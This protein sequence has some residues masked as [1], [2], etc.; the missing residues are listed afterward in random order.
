MATPAATTN[1]ETVTNAAAASLAIKTLAKSAVIT[2]R[3]V[4]GTAPELSKKESG[5]RDIKT[6]KRN[7]SAHG[8]STRLAEMLSLA[9]VGFSL[10][11][12][13]AMITYEINY[14]SGISG[15]NICGRVGNVLAG[16]CFILLGKAA[17]IPVAFGAVWSVILFFRGAVDSSL[18]K[19]FGVFVFT[20]AI[21]ILLE[22]RIPFDSGNGDP[23]GGLL[24]SLTT[25]YV[26]H[27]FGAFGTYLIVGIV[28]SIAFTMATD[29]AFVPLIREAANHLKRA[30][31]EVRDRAVEVSEAESWN[32]RMWALV[33]GFL[34]KADTKKDGKKD[35]KSLFSELESAD[36]KKPLSNAATLV[37]NAPIVKE[38]PAPAIPVEVVKEPVA[39]KIVEKESAKKK[40]NKTGDATKD[41]TQAALPFP[42]IPYTLPEPKLLDD[43][44]KGAVGN[45]NEDVRLMAQRIEEVLHSFG[46]EVGVVGASRGPAVTL[47]ELEMGEGVTVNLLTAR[48]HDLAIRLKSGG[49]RFVYPIPGKSTVGVEVPNQ[50]REFVRLRELIDEVPPSKVKA[51]IPLYLGRDVM[52]QAVVADLAEMPHVLIA[53]QT[54]SGKSACLN[55]ILCSLLLARD[56]DEVKLILVDPKQVEFSKYDAIPHLMCPIVTVARKVPIVLDWVIAEMENRYEL[57]AKGG[58]RKISDF[59]AI[60]KKELKERM[61][62]YYVPDETQLRLPYIV[63][64]VDEMNDLMIQAKKDMEDR[65]TRIA[66]KSRAVGIHLILATQRPSVNVITGTIKANL[67]TRIAFQTAQGN[68]SRVILDQ[69]GAEDLLGKGDFLYKPPGTDKFVRAQGTWVGDEEIERLVKH[70][71]SHGEP[72][73]DIRLIQ[74]RESDDTE[75]GEDDNDAPAAHS[76][77]TFSGGWSDA[78]FERAVEETL[79]SNRAA[80]S[81]LQ[82]AFAIGYNRATRIL[83]AMAQLGIVSQ[84]EGSKVRRIMITKEEWAARKTELLQ[85][86]GKKDGVA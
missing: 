62:E 24:G 45:L 81:H 69:N 31:E 9:A 41:T 25:P 75:D 20:A 36:A 32:A 22:H 33:P 47:F 4:K 52:N 6:R 46:V 13:A 42:A 2:D 61:G 23:R 82:R 73:Y 80:A 1:T 56:P 66:Q 18:V 71:K 60:S 10:F 83:D 21:C 84:Y 59:N 39:D 77:P 54:G 64:I 43:V 12:I 86:P 38:E 7:K 35:K 53:G 11:L 58:V 63:V 74:I 37:V 34:R 5:E 50:K 16:A 17:F 30:G 67:P 57:L 15:S 72:R 65:I 28:A 78:L 3:G 48:R 26:A 44:K 68:D 19:A 8:E 29:F 76:E 40:T 27:G 51:A 49:V 14:N 85:G 79:E 70:A 55:A